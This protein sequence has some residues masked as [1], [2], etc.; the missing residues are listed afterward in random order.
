MFGRGA[1]ACSW[2]DSAPR[3]SGTGFCVATSGM[4]GLGCCWNHMAAGNRPA[5]LAG[6]TRRDDVDD[7]ASADESE[8]ASRRLLQSLE[9]TISCDGDFCAWLFRGVAY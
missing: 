5:T 9:S 4:V 6:G 7:D 2:R 3:E 8:S 1:L